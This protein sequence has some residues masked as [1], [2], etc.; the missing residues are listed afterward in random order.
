MRYETPMQ[1]REA[2]SY[3]AADNLWVYDIEIISRYVVGLKTVFLGQIPLSSFNSNWRAPIELLEQIIIAC[4][5]IRSRLSE[6][7]VAQEHRV[8]VVIN[9]IV[10]HVYRLFTQSYHVTRDVIDEE[11]YYDSVYRLLRELEL[12]DHRPRLHDSWDFDHDAA[13]LARQKY[14]Q[15]LLDFVRNNPAEVVATVYDWAN[16]GVGHDAKIS[17]ARESEFNLFFLIESARNYSEIYRLN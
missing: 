12:R 17:T 9:T 8:H 4:G 11:R 2:L 7:N 5:N 3:L 6:L 14:M 10:D 15:E 1:L 16:R 13:K